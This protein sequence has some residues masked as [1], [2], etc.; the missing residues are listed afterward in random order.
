MYDALSH[1]RKNCHHEQCYQIV[2]SSSRLDMGPTRR[3]ITISCVTNL[4]SQL[5][6]VIHIATLYIPGTLHYIVVE[7]KQQV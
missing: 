6:L 3:Q 4:F 2:K 1:T 5:V 7:R